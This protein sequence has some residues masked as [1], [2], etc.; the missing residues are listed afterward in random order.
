MKTLKNFFLIVLIVGLVAC[1]GDGG[2][3]S[4][5]EN[6][7]GTEEES[8]SEGLTAFE[9]R[10]I[11]TAESEFC[12]ELLDEPL[13][14]NL[15]FGC[16]WAKM[17]LMP[18]SSESSALLAA[19]DE[20]P[21]DLD[22]MLLGEDGFFNNISTLRSGRFP[23]F[24]FSEFNFPFSN[25]FAMDPTAGVAET[26]EDL[27]QIAINNSVSAIDLQQRLE[28]LIADFIELEEIL[29]VVIDDSSFSF[30]LPAE[31]FR[32]A[33]D[34]NVTYNDARF[35]MSSVKGS[36]ASLNLAI[37]YDIGVDIA[38][39]VQRGDIDQE[40]LVADLNG[41]GETVKG[42]TVDTTAFLTLND[43]SI[44]TDAK[45]R[46]V[47]SLIHLRTALQTIDAGE[48]SDFFTPIINGGDLTDTIQFFAE[49]STS[50]DE[51][52]TLV[53]LYWLEPNAEGEVPQLNMNLK[54]FFESPPDA[55]EVDI[56]AGDPF[57]YENN[58]ATPVGNY[59]STFLD[60]LVEP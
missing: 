49:L 1:G 11:E 10:D 5:E 50:L 48:T 18:E 46:A 6:H 2:S 43:A 4:D 26:V 54:R 13:S 51:G 22:A 3:L 57:V 41:T 32:L 14:S 15:A 12:G 45:S 7:P 20:D 28:D 53:P 36:I 33:E 42:V 60:G 30:T 58:R 21:F 52:M 38:D 59:F 37:A 27:L 29:A 35:F 8:I 39:V 44:I 25:F 24:N 56:E 9:E 16:F 31:L 34:L 55:A 17:L 23:L 40:I 19:F 47:S